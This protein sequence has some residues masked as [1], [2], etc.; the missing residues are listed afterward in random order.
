MNNSQ[1]LGSLKGTD[2]LDCLLGTYDED[3]EVYKPVKDQEIQ[4]TGS[5]SGL[6]RLET[7]QVQAEDSIKN[8]IF[9]ESYFYRVVFTVQFLCV[10]FCGEQVYSVGVVPLKL[11]FFLLEEKD[12]LVIVLLD[13]AVK[14]F[15]F[16]ELVLRFFMPV[17]S[18]YEIEVDHREIFRMNVR[19][20]SFYVDLYAAI[21]WEDIFFTGFKL[22]RHLKLATLVHLSTLSSVVDSASP[23]Q[24][25][26][27]DERLQVRLPAQL[28]IQNRARQLQQ[29]R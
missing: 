8:V 28:H 7:L 6:A 15:F 10:V 22:K 4:R 24:D 21:P 2:R 27:P 3:F 23:V 18:K 25:V 14:I 12:P 9:R 19:E 29:K 1:L 13:R 17:Y 11:S 20:V 16:F 26:Q 5:K